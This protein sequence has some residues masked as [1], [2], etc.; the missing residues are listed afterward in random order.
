LRFDLGQ[1]QQAETRGENDFVAPAYASKSAIGQRVRSILASQA[2]PK[3]AT[4]IIGTETALGK[5]ILVP[6]PVS[7]FHDLP[8]EGGHADFAFL[9][10]REF[11][12]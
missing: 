11:A 5:A 4:G 10:E 7:G 12:S 6:F 1:A 2:D 8:S 3:G 9:S